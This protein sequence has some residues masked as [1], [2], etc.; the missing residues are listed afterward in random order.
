MTDLC[1]RA[2]TGTNHPAHQAIFICDTCLLFEEGDGDGD[3][4]NR[5]P[6]PSC[7]C[8]SCAENCHAGHEVYFVGMG[9]CT[10]DC[11][12]MVCGALQIMNNTD[13]EESAV[14]HQCQLADQSAQEA[15]RLGYTKQVR[16]FN[17]P[18]PLKVPPSLAAAAGDVEEETEATKNNEGGDDDDDTEVDNKKDSEDDDDDDD[19]KVCIDCNTTMGGYTYNSFT[20][21]SLAESGGLCHGLIQ[22]AE[23]LAENSKDTFWV[24][25]SNASEGDTDGDDGLCDLEI[26]ARQIYKQ[27]VRT[28]SLQSSNGIANNNNG[29][30]EVESAVGGAEW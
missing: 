26:L 27:H 19:A 18:I 4:C 1:T 6:L 7:I 22:Q 9:P 2:I 16:A 17:A 24:P 13:G 30:E 25:D 3:D 11:P 29:E 15:K 23:V 5:A 10:C 8:Q 28:Y 20:L 12:S 14:Q 21:P